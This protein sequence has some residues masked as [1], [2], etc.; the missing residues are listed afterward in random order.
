MGSTAA[1]VVGI[2]V[3]SRSRTV[4]GTCTAFHTAILIDNPGLAMADLENAVRTDH[5]AV[6]ATNAFVFRQ[7]KDRSVLKISKISHECSPL[8]LI[9]TNGAAI[10]NVK[11]KIARLI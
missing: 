5:L 10:Q 8:F 6:A 1:A 2:Y 7:M 4:F 11:A 3:Y 9:Y